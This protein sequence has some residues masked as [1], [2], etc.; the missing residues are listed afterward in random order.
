LNAEEDEEDIEEQDL[1]EI[2]PLR[3]SITSYGADYPADSL[4]QRIN[5]DSIFIPPFQRAYVWNISQASRFIESLLLGLPVPGIFLSREDKSNKLLVI[6]GQ[7]RLRSLQYFYEGIFSNTG[8]EFS[9]QGVQKQFDGLTYKTLTPEDRRRLDDSIIHATI[10]RQEQPSDDESSIYYIFERLNTGGT[11]LTNQ[12]IRACIYH[13]E[14][15]QFLKKLNNEAAW[16]DI[17]GKTSSRMRD[18]ELILRFLALYYDG[19]KYDRPMKE[20]LNNFMG[21]NRDIS[22]ER[23]CEMEKRFVDVIKTVRRAIGPSAFRPQK[24]LNAAVFDAVMIGLA[25]RLETGAITDIDMIK[26]RYFDLI[27]D[28]NF[29]LSSTKATADK[30]SVIS[31]IRMAI[32]AFNDVL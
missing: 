15:N 14:F 16:R 21:S 30:E 26:T 23:Q 2:I 10:I 18:Q 20:F 29:L 28:S 8:K 31:R 17:Y 3:Y 6:D 7:Q 19:D 25:K 24:S 22:P 5:N 13:G 9:L 27:K 1:D 32:T 4:V 11:L 12:E